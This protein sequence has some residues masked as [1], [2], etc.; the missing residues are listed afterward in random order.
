MSKHL[1]PRPSLEQLKKQAK[2]L[3]RAHQQAEPGAVQRIR[4]HLPRLSQ[5]AESEIPQ[6]EFSLQDAQLVLAR[7]YG[8]QSWPKLVAA[9]SAQTALP[10]SDSGATG[11]PEVPP[12]SFSDDELV[13]VQLEGIYP[14]S[15]PVPQ[16]PNQLIETFL[17]LL[18][19]EDKVVPIQIGRSEGQALA[20]ALGGTPLLRPLPYNL[21]QNL[22]ERFGGEPQ[23][24]VIHR[25]EN[26]VFYAHLLVRKEDETIFLDCRPSDGMVVATLTGAPIYLTRELLQRTGLDIDLDSLKRE[27]A[28]DIS[29]GEGGAL[30]VRMA[31]GAAETSQ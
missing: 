8:F 14:Q 21:L 13:P 9:L 29:T 30:Q 5:A 2:N 26:Q 31:R 4:E 18:T 11:W 20:G 27:G 23:K 1:P 10:S 19:A 15:H 24:L 17:V 6:A 28:L 12:P 7:E 16:A 3:H 22:M 25:W